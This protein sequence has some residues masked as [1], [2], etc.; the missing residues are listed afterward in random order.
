[1][2]CR[3]R[4]TTV[5]TLTIHCSGGAIGPL[6]SDPTLRV[7]AKSSF[8]DFNDWRFPRSVVCPRPRQ[9][10][11]RWSRD[12]TMVSEATII[13]GRKGHAP[14]RFMVTALLVATGGVPQS[15][16]LLRGAATRVQPMFSRSGPEW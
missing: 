4:V 3:C 15:G 16:R 2:Y 1:M 8:T 7:R 6:K 14:S 5:I 11:A 12:S 13:G 10:I 9:R